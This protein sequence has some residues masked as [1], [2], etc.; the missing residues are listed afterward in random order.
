MIDGC[1]VLPFYCL[2]FYLI[3][4]R[5]QLPAILFC[6]MGSHFVGK[7]FVFVFMRLLVSVVH[8]S[9]MSGVGLL[10]CVSWYIRMLQF[11]GCFDWNFHYFIYYVWCEG[12]LMGLFHR[13]CASVFV[14]GV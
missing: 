4:L 10:I 11:K 5:M 8:V 1:I 14:C 2:D 6:T 9:V 13:M 12:F 3:D 7:E